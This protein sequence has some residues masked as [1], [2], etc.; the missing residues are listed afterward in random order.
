M[1]HKMSISNQCIERRTGSSCHAVVFPSKHNHIQDRLASMK[2]M[3][4]SW[5]SKL[6]Q[7]DHREGILSH[8]SDGP[9]A[10]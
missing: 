4:A 1:E 8:L 5:L 10:S 6:T 9:H 3:Y 2:D 7:A